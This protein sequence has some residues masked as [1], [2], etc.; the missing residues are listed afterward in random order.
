MDNNKT[1]KAVLDADEWMRGTGLPYWTV[2]ALREMKVGDGLT[3]LDFKG[4]GLSANHEGSVGVSV[5]RKRGCWEFSALWLSEIGR[6]SRR[7]GH[8]FV[9][10]ARFK[11]LSGRKIEAMSSVDLDGMRLVRLILRR[12]STLTRWAE[13][14]GDRLAAGALNPSHF[15]TRSKPDAA[16]ERM[17]EAWLSQL[18][19][20][21]EQASSKAEESRHDRP[22]HQ[23]NACSQEQWAPSGT[24]STPRWPQARSNP[25]E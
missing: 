20:S 6:N 11:L 18:A 12:S 17:A 7:R 5:E 8:I 9:P 25:N 4:P 19:G 15:P 13:E 2:A 14:S 24:G 23:A 3:I 10:G 21:R 22:K 1:F 16:P